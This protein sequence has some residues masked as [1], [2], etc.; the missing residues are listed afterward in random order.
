ME[1]SIDDVITT[2]LMILDLDAT[3]RDA[4]I[5]QMAQPLEDT[6]RVTD[7][8]A[9]VRA[10]Q[11]REQEGG[12]TGMEMGVAIPHAKSEAVTRASVVFAR[13]Q[14][15]VDFGGDAE[16]PSTLLFLIAAPAGS[17]D[18]HV[19]LLSRLARRLIHESFRQ[20][21]HDA[22]SPDAVMQVLRD[23]VKL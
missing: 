22:D 9:Y 14:R 23:E 2:D 21:L 18:L 15:G 13:S 6:G 17:E 1:L 16:V 8:M 12:G 4:A 19:T 20:R 7:R 10:V 11:E 5:E 3:E